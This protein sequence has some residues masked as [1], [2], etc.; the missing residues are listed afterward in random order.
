VLVGAAT[1]DT[2]I[3]GNFFEEIF[4][5][6]WGVSSAHASQALTGVKGIESTSATQAAV[7]QGVTEVHDSVTLSVD[8]VRAADSTSDI[9]FDRIHSIRAAIADGTYETADKLD[10]AIERLLDRL[11]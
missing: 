6:I 5:Q 3:N 1:N 7:G 9:R 11:A 2:F 8:A 10:G 4:M